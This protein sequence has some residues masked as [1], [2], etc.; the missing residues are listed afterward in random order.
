MDFSVNLKPE[1]AQYLFLKQSDMVSN[2]WRAIFR[3]RCPENSGRIVEIRR[4]MS[5]FFHSTGAAETGGRKALRLP[6]GPV[7]F[8]DT[9]VLPG[10]P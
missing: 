6:Q 2:D 9:A 1:N 5:S 10:R 7:L 4:T 8:A 3:H